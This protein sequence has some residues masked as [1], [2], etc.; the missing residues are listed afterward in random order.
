LIDDEAGV[1]KIGALMSH[2]IDSIP[3]RLRATD[4]GV[5][6]PEVPA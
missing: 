6:Q 5:R 4:I 3:A 1:A 2:V